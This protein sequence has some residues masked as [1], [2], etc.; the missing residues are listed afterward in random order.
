MPVELTC[1]I[2]GTP[3]TVRPSRVAKGAKYCTYRC[4]QVGEGQKGGVA[5]GEQ[6]KALD[7]GK[8]Y[9]KQR[10]RHTHRV[11]MEQM[12]GRPLQP[13]EVVHHRDGNKRN[14]APENLELLTNQADHARQHVSQ[15]LA[16]RRARHGY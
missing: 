6:V 5:R 7:Q 8:T 16:T 4:H 10:G 9:T 12:L 13:G 3:F 15:M 2:C 11:I 1:C 14:N